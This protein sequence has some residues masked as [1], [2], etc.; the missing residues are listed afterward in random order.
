MRYRSSIS[1]VRVPGGAQRQRGSI[2][3]FFLFFLMAL[4]SFGAFAIDLARVSVVRNELQN[5]ADAAALAGASG[6]LV[7]GSSGPNWAQAQTKTTNAV[8]L[9]RSDGQTLTTGTIQAGY[10][11]LTGSPAGMQPTT[12]T[13]GID[14]APAVQVTV[15]RATNQNGGAINLF[16]G[17]LLNLLSAPGSATAVAVAAAPSTVGTGGLF[18]VVLDQCV[19]NQYWDATTNQ[20]LIDPSTGQAYEFLITNG[21]TYGSSCSAGQWTSFLTNANDVPTVS[22]LIAN[23]NPTPL[24][25]G[26]SIWVEPGA[27]TSLYGSVP[28]N[29][30]V[31][32]PVASQIASKTSVSIVAFAAFYIDASVGGSD[33]Y[34]QGH[35]V[36]GYTMPTAATGVGPNYGAYIAPRLA[37]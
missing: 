12:I 20:P 36:G 15:T 5:A 24:S 22:N 23:G 29:V 13:P 11:N 25:I 35:F 27:K 9:N 8:A 28:T 17:G 32:M 1:R 33:K 16:L 18:P 10:W 3:L 34:I 4:L 6:L 14:D 7:A 21:Q 30:T 37:L 31:I 2:A 26:D 19:F